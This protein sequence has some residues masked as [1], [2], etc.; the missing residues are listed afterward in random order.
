MGEKGKRRELERRGRWERVITVLVFTV[1]LHLVLTVAVIRLLVI[2]ATLRLIIVVML[3]RVG[4]W[5]RQQSSSSLP[6]V[7][8]KHLQVPNQH[9][10]DDAPH[11]VMQRLKPSHVE[12]GCGRGR[13]RHRGR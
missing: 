13:R 5:R 7:H 8:V 4:G 3:P 6:A 10:R 2:G 12:E 1:V 9:G 11:G